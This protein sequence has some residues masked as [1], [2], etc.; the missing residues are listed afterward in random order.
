MGKG[1]SS[2]PPATAG[3]VD[4]TTRTRITVRAESK[5]DLICQS[6]RE[7]SDAVVDVIHSVFRR[8]ARSVFM[9]S[10]TIQHTVAVASLYWIT[11]ST[12]LDGTALRLVDR[13]AP[14]R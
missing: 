12:A 13:D 4:S 11:A 10:N 14:D 6:S 7:G 8:I 5:L 1:G 9:T 3:N 2:A